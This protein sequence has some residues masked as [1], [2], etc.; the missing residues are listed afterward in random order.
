MK[1]AGVQH[2][3]ALVVVS[4]GTLYSLQRC[5]MMRG[6]LDR[7]AGLCQEEQDISMLPAIIS[8]VLKLFTI[9]LPSQGN[10]YHCIPPK[11]N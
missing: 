8:I 4:G 3:Q 10:E 2:L 5:S 7:L 9:S 6:I 11:K 1:T